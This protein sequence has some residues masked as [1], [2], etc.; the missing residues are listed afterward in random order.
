[1]AVAL[2]RKGAMKFYENKSRFEQSR[3]EKNS[4]LLYKS[5]K[6]EIFKHNKNIG[7]M[8]KGK[9]GAFEKKMLG[10]QG[11][12]SKLFSWRNDKRLWQ[13]FL[14][15]LHI[16]LLMMTLES[17]AFAKPLKEL[18]EWGKWDV[19][20]YVIFLLPVVIWVFFL[21]PL[22][23]LWV[24]RSLR[25]RKLKKTHSLEQVSLPHDKSVRL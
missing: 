8:M 4:K 10:F 2:E 25:E 13:N 18:G 21:A 20:G 16:F 3:I 19:I 12:K 23:L 15:L 17:P 7:G 9:I 22:L 14:T 6:K 24:F 5:L 11:K 1:M